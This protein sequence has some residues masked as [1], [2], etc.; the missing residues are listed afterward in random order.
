MYSDAAESARRGFRRDA[1]YCSARAAGVPF[2]VVE[3]RAMA[4]AGCGP[5]GRRRHTH[6]D[7]PARTGL[8]TRVAARRVVESVTP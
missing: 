3:R 6:R 8:G 2:G 7:G 5:G 1:R 4:N